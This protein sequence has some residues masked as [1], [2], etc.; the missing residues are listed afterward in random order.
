MSNQ[1]PELKIIPLSEYKTSEDNSG[2]FSGYANNYGVLDSYDDI[3]LP[4][5]A[6]DCL[7]ELVEAGFGAADHRWGITSEIGILTDAYEDETGLFV[8]VSYHPDEDSQKIRQKVN[9]RLANKKKVGMSIGYWT[10][11]R[12]YVVGE[13]AIP[14]L[15][16]P[17]QEVLTYLKEKQPIVRLLKKIHVVEPSVV[18]MG[19]NRASGVT[20][21]K[22]ETLSREEIQ[23]ER[24]RLIS[25]D[26]LRHASEAGG[27]GIAKKLDILKLKLRMISA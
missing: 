5:C 10:I 14:F 2:S 21:G 13:E 18:S 12:E 9:N 22:S 27:A 6:K 25:L 20:E 19:A 15:K 1:K 3:T 26:G 23:T 8:K 17:P 24:K 4:G 16:N 7:D 11:E